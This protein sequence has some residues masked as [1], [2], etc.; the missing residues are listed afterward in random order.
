MKKINPTRTRTQNIII[1]ILP[2]QPMPHP[3]II[4]GPICQPRFSP[5]WARVA[6]DESKTIERV[7]AVIVPAGINLKCFILL[8]LFSVDLESPAFK[9]HFILS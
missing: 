9:R 2:N 5:H 1:N 6:V 8:D 4:P 3:P 7:M